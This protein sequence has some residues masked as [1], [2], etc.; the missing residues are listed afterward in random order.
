MRYPQTKAASH[1]P[2]EHLQY[3]LSM[4]LLMDKKALKKELRP[5]VY[6]SRYNSYIKLELYH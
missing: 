2:E 6:D 3:S 1:Y 4:E 5:Q